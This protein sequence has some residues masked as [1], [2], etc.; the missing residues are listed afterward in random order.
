MTDLKASWSNG[1]TRA[2]PSVTTGEIV[3]FPASALA[4]GRDLRLQASIC[5]CSG[6]GFIGSVEDGHLVSNVQ[7]IIEASKYMFRAVDAAINVPSEPL[8]I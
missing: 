3:V 2:K 4:H 6:V 7:Q 1:P 5:L 8:F